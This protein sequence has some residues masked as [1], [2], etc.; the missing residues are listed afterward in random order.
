MNTATNP[1]SPKCEVKIDWGRSQS[2]TQPD[3]ANVTL[4]FLYRTPWDEPPVPAT[5][6]LYS[7]PLTVMRVTT[8]QVAYSSNDPTV[9]WGRDYVYQGSAANADLQESARTTSAQVHVAPP[10]GT[11]GFELSASVPASVRAT[12][13]SSSR[14][15][16]RFSAVWL[17]TGQVYPTGGISQIR[18]QVAA[19]GLKSSYT[20]SG[21]PFGEYQIIA[22]FY[23]GGGG[24]GDTLVGWSSVRDTLLTVNQ[25][26]TIVYTPTP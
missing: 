6:L 26:E 25:P 13:P 17:D 14:W 16:A 19:D 1:A 21:L 20:I 22:T 24:P 10:A 3:D 5:D 12:K 11:L 7:S 9:D 2:A 15:Y 23:I 18:D 8:H 4:Y